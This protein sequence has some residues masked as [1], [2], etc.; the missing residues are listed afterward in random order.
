MINQIERELIKHGAPKCAA[1]FYLSTVKAFVKQS[2]GA[3]EWHHALPVGCNGWSVYKRAKWNLFRVMRIFHEALRGLL[4]AILPGNAALRRAITTFR[5]GGRISVLNGKELEIRSL[6]GTVTLPDAAK[7][8][9]VSRGCLSSFCF[10]RNI[11]WPRFSPLRYRGSEVRRLVGTMFMRDACKKL[12]VS[13]A[14]L[15]YFCSLHNIRWSRHRPQSKLN[16]AKVIEI[17]RL[18]S[19]GTPRIEIAKQFRLRPPHVYALVAN[20]IWKQAEAA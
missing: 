5:M 15:N 4:L 12:Q 1:R 6:A 7:K 8:L 2:D 18:A 17:R 10:S 20:T 16:K 19:M 11:R 14:C 3:G 9:G 13:F